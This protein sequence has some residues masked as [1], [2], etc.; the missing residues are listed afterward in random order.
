MNENRTTQIVDEELEE[1]LDP[2]EVL[3]DEIFEKFKLAL[4]DEDRLLQK[5]YKFCDVYSEFEF[6]E[7]GFNMEESEDILK[8]A[9]KIKEKLLISLEEKL[10]L[11]FENIQIDSLNI[12]IE[13]T[14]KVEDDTFKIIIDIFED[15]FDLEIS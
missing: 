4:L 8:R 13:F 5:F 3:R 1:D 12:Q 2:R 6:D 14:T 11:N 9:H 7:S 10:S 15:S